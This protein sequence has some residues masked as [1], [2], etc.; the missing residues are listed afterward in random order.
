MQ[1]SAVTLVMAIRILLA[2]LAI[3]FA[4]CGVPPS[5]SPAPV[6][7]LTEQPPAPVVVMT[8]PDVEVRA[9][10]REVKRRGDQYDCYGPTPRDAAWREENCKDVPP[11]E[12]RAASASVCS[13]RR[14]LYQL[15]PTEA[16]REWL[17][18]HCNPSR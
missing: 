13:E 1:H 2:A 9:A 7:A 18:V 8:D 16:R 15:Q 11:L 3:T 4:A 12:V 14:A 6:A 17:A 5:S 10:D